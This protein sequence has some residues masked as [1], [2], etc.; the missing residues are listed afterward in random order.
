MTVL[1]GGNPS[2]IKPGVAGK[3]IIGGGLISLGLEAVS[4]WLVPFALLLDAFLY[5]ATVQCT[6]DP[7][8]FPTFTLTDVT[9]LIGGVLN[10][11]SGATLDKIKDV[12]MRYLWFQY[13]ECT[14][15]GTPAI[16]TGPTAPGGLAIPTPTS[17]TVC[18]TGT[19]SGA[20]DQFASPT[21]D[22]RN[23]TMLE[24]AGTD[25]VSLDTYGGDIRSVPS[26]INQ[27]VLTM[28]VVFPPGSNNTVS[29]NLE[30]YLSDRSSQV[31]N[32]GLPFNPVTGGLDQTKTRTYQFTSSVAYVNIHAL[33]ITDPAGPAT[34]TINADWYCG[35]SAPGQLTT[36]CQADPAVLTLL[37]QIN[38]LVVL[39]QRQSVPFAYQPSTTHAGLTGSG[40]ITF[41]GLIGVK[42]TPS[43]IPSSA[44]V[45]IGDPDSLW[46]DSWI[47]WGNPDGWAD[48]A[49]LTSAPYV[50]M[51][52]LAGQYTKLGYTLR[53]GLTVDIQELIREA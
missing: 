15:V 43:A 6:G 21:S 2:Q 7:P 53:P 25:T 51:P 10:P 29:Q 47:R 52:I 12:V 1:C 46:L 38:D 17:P 37:K 40:E 50:S 23:F 18:F 28:H 36:P 19:Y 22:T 32:A 41:S 33:Q 42:V 13:C 4:P 35:S 34:I 44:G 16:D 30:G 45:V 31:L 5:D 26:G 8:A 14:V 27:M 39:I 48:R 20:P 24:P 3:N 9:N 11:N 49:F